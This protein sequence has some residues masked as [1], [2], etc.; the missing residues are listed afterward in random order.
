[1]EIGGHEVTAEIG[2]GGSGVVYRARDRDG[3]LV[4]IKVLHGPATEPALRFA[5]EARLLRELG[6]GFV[7]LLDSGLT[8]EGLP[9]LVMPFVE[10]GTLRD[11]LRGGRLE[12]AETV[13]LGKRLAA[14]LAR[15]HAKGVVHRDLKPE[16]ILFT[17]EGD[18]LVADLGLG[19]HVAGVNPASVAI[20]QSR[21]V[22]GTAGYAAP[23]QMVATREAGPA[24][25]VFSL[26]AILY[27]CLA[28]HGPFDERSP[29]AAILRA[30][31]EAYAPLAAERPEAPRWLVRAIE[32]ALVADPAERIPNA[33][34]LL[35]LL[36]S[37]A[38]DRRRSLV[39]VLVL[40]LALGAGIAMLLHGDHAEKPVE[41]PRPTCHLELVETLGSRA[42]SHAFEIRAIAFSPDGRFAI[43]GGD[44]QAAR[45]F[46]VPSGKEV[47]AL[48]RLR[49]NVGAV[50]VARGA[51]TA[52][53][54][55]EGDSSV[56]VWRASGTESHP[57]AK[58]PSAV[59]LSPDGTR[60][61]V[62][63][64]D[65]TVEIRSLV[66]WELEGE[67]FRHKAGPVRA[68]AFSPD[69]S[70]T[71]SVA[72][73]GARLTGPV[74]QVTLLEGKT[75]C[76]AFA[77]DGRAAVGLS[78]QVTIAG[79]PPRP[80]EAGTDV[81]SVGFLE[82]GSP[83]AVVWPG[84]FRAWLP[85]PI[86]RSLD[87]GGVRA[88]AFSPDGKWLLSAAASGARLFEARSGL[89]VGPTGP[90]GAV[91]A[92]AP[93]GKTGSVLAGSLDGTVRVW[94]LATGQGVVLGRHA[95]RVYA[96]AVAAD[97]RR[98]VS[99]SWDGA[100]KVWNLEQRSEEGEYAGH[101]RGK[102]D[103]RSVDAVA[104]SAAGLVASA[105]RAGEIHLW[106]LETGAAG[107]VLEGHASRVHF[108]GF[109]SGG[110][111]VSCDEDGLVL[112]WDGA[113]SRKLWSSARAITAMAVAG[114]R[115]VA[116]NDVRLVVRDV[117]T[118]NLL[119]ELEGGH[120]GT[121]FSVAISPDGTKA[122]SGGGRDGRICLWDL[123]TG[124][125]LDRVDLSPEGDYVHSVAFMPDGKE[126][127]AGTFRGVLLRYALR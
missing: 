90:R 30:E 72:R 4:A 121:I 28:G 5:R 54:A 93:I 21:D 42:F 75:G 38:G 114:A 113:A 88:A 50:A 84:T 19:K 89:E 104:I 25:D 9:Y 98:A 106:S 105:G 99:S 117:E 59:A 2:R 43:T 47:R 94:D 111:L 92:L 109:A 102:K 39:L 31:N 33:A 123:G 6:D 87:P 29:I 37:G 10:G 127:L 126:I 56:T 12:V 103:G 68:V 41:V 49:G 17:K 112:A 122:A 64:A 57:T 46:E 45:I 16:N 60:A 82:D 52:L 58:P 32:R 3:S 35:G 53:V 125:L 76:A 67:S 1:M 55:V 18:P 70:R 116:G 77:P 83:C 7:P 23:E 61:L 34:A 91:S 101:E 79:S 115:V 14:T 13:A 8:L 124:A 96:V 27:E 11:R 24:A 48:P 51:E 15:A 86:E 40:V 36:E 65:G 120:E 26:G 78:N 119:R 107:R 85:G 81:M 22:R 97:G 66:A 118:G 74:E 80:L 71:L 20:T 110:R 44:D 62:G 73:K 63:L 95:T 108:V 100:V 69:G